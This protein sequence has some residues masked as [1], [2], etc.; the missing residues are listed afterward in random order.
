MISARIDLGSL[1]NLK[2]SDHNGTTEMIEST[3]DYRECLQKLD[4]DLA[5]IEKQRVSLKQQQLTEKEIEKALEPHYTFYEQLKDEV[6]WYERIQRRDFGDIL[7]LTELGRILISLR[8]VNGI[9]QRELAAKMGVDESQVS[10]DERNEYHGITLDRA[11][12]ILDVMQE[13]L[14]TRVEERPVLR[15]QPATAK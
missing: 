3:K 14:V 15:K 10:R 6:S 4:Q 7:N 9:T 13:K 2:L 5:F 1:A 11:Q 12:K 8:I